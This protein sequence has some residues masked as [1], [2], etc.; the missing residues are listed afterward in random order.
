MSIFCRGDRS[1]SEAPSPFFPVR[2]YCSYLSLVRMKK[3]RF[4]L[5]Y[6]HALTLPYF[7]HTN[8][9]IISFACLPL[10]IGPFPLNSH[11][12]TFMSYV[13]THICK[14]THTHIC[15]FLNLGSEYE[16]AYMA[17]VFLLHYPLLFPYCL[18]SLYL[19]IPYIFT[20]LFM[21]TVVFCLHVRLRTSAP[22]CQKKAPDLLT[23]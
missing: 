8:I 9:L 12:S 21:Y 1:P 3:T 13:H 17:R 18:L 22:A 7:A 2:N 14:Y 5:W 20:Y 16:K 11:H 4:F 19:F 23:F 10:P 15:L 6:L